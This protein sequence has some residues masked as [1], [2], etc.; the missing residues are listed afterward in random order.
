M[1]KSFFDGFVIGISLGVLVAFTVW[2]I[3][4]L[5]KYFYVVA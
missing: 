2:T 3:T 5:L 1:P 4:L